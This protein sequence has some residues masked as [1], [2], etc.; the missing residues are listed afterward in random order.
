M[1]MS[2]CNIR[3]E[4]DEYLC[5]THGTR[6]DVEEGESCPSC[7]NMTNTGRQHLDRIK[8]GLKCSAKP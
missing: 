4:G 2:K 1:S 8:E 7:E 5:H 3:R 6:W